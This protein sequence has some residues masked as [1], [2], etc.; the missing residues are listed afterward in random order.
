MYESYKNITYLSQAH[1]NPLKISI[2]KKFLFNRVKL[3]PIIGF[4]VLFGYLT[5]ACSSDDVE[6][7]IDCLGESAFT[8]IDVE[9]D[10]GD[11][12]VNFSISYT[13]DLSLRSV[14]W[15][16]GDGNSG[17]GTSTSHTYSDAGSY[18]VKAKVELR[19]GGKTCEPEISR[20]VTVE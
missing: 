12:T 13:G 16:F 7:V 3:L 14:S 10:D 5:T 19:D 17:S 9:N 20:T 15:D 1:S 4:L 18:S 11:R 2:M 6:S 8:R